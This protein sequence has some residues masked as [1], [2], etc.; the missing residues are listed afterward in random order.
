MKLEPLCTE[1]L[2]IREF[3]SADREGLMA[4]VRDQ[5]A[6]KYMMFSMKDAAELDSFLSM[7][8]AGAADPARC[9][10]HCAIAFREHPAVCIG[11][12]SLMGDVGNPASAEIGYFIRRDFW[13]RGLT[14]EAARALVD[15]GFSKLALHRVWGKCDTLNPGSARVLEKLGMKL[16]GTSREHVWLHDHWR[17]SHEYGVLDREWAVMKPAVVPAGAA[18]SRDLFTIFV[19]R[20]KLFFDNVVRTDPDLV[21]SLLDKSFVEYGSS[22]KQYRYRLDDIFGASDDIIT[23]EDN[24]AELVDL[25]DGAKLLRYVAVK[26]SA[27]GEC[28]RSNR[29][30]IWRRAEGNAADATENTWRL[31]FHQGTDWPT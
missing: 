1:R 19:A 5:D 9:E 11:C 18:E 12:V 13:G 24:S 25:A 3:S 31:V 4:F 7:A 27:S 23:M 6:L 22:G 28:K 2:V 14:L 30:S 29:C 15:W 20:E 16:E 17:S 10:Y 26:Q 21:A 8:T